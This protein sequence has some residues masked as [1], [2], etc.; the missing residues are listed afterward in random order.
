MALVVLQEEFEVWDG[1]GDGEG[2]M[3]V[4][5]LFFYI[6]SVEGEAVEPGGVHLKALLA[7]DLAEGL[8]AGDRPL[9]AILG[10]AIGWRAMGQSPTRHVGWRAMGQAPARHEGLEFIGAKEIGA[11]ERFQSGKFCSFHC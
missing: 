1:Q 2:E 6:G 5:Q 7:V 10:F 8:L 3:E 4:A 11:E 9:C